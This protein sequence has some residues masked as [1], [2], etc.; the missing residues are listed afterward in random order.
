[1]S[2]GYLGL[3]SDLG[4]RRSQLQQALARIA[5]SPGIRL[6][7]TA[8]FYRTAPL[9][10]V[11]QEWFMN[12]VARIETDRSAR[13][14]LACT[15][16]IERA[17]GRVRTERWGPRTIDLDLLWLEGCEE[18]SAELTL[19]HPGAHLRSFVLVP[20]CELA[21]GLVLRGQTLDHWRARADP[22]AIEAVP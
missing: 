5:G 15:Q 17:L 13:A 6:V 10:P 21:P 1:M 3:G 18:D 2:R 12:T 7:R 14:I 11:A 16:A 19:P 8:G 9:G 20:W 4:E 22:L